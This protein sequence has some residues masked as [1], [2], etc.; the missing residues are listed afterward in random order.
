MNNFREK[1][2]ES[3]IGRRWTDAMALVM[4]TSRAGEER[5]ESSKSE[6]FASN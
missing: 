1:I 6:S 3:A 2:S 5:Q 4:M